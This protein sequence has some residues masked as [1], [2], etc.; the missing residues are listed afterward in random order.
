M[1]VTP[2]PKA[3]PSSIRNGRSAAVP[4]SKTVSMW[5]ISSTRGRLGPAAER[6]DDGRPEAPGRIGPDLDWAPSPLEERR[7]DQPRSRRRPR[8]CSSRS[9]C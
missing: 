5:P 2:G 9:R 8:A 3:M 1:S 6:R 7:D 4:G